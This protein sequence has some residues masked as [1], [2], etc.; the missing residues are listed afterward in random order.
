LISTG[1]R[2][3]EQAIKQSALQ[4]KGIGSPLG[5][6]SSKGIPTVV[7]SMIPLSSP[8][9]SIP[10][11]SC[12]ALQSSVMPRGSVMDYQQ[13][14]TT[15]HPYQTPPV[16][17]FVGHNT[18]W[19]SQFPFRGPWMAS[20]QASAPDASTRL[21]VLPNTE[22]IKST[23]L[24]ESSVLHSSGI[25]H[26]S[27]GPVVH[28][29]VPTST[30]LLDPKEVIA[31]PGQ[32]TKDPKSRRR[33]KTP[34]SEDLGQIV[35]QPQFQPEP[36]FT[37]AL[38]SHLS[39]SVAIATPTGSASKAT[40]EKMVLSESPISC[41][42]NLKRVSDDVEQRAT[43]SEET[44]SKVKEARLQAENAAALSAA[45]VSN[46]QEIWSQL[47]KQNSSGLVSDVEAKLASAAVAIAAAAAVAKAAAAA[48]N[49]ASSAALQAKLM[50]EEALFA[51]GYGNPSQGNGTS[52]PDSV[53]ILGKAT[54]ASILK[55]EN[56]TNSSNSIIIA[57]KEAVRKRVE[58]ASAAT[59]RAENM[60]AIVK[61]AELAAEAISQA[62]K[63]VAMGDPLPLS[64]LVKAGPGGFW[65]VSREPFEL[66][67]KPNDT[68][69]EHLNNDSIGGGPNI[70][71]K[72]S[73]DRSSDKKE[74][75]ITTYEK[76]SI[77]TEMPRESMQDQMRLVDGISATVTTNEKD[78]RGQKGRK[79][80]DLAKTIGVV[81][82]SEIGSRFAA[83]QNESEKAVET[84]KQNSIKEGSLVE[85]CDL[86][87]ILHFLLFISVSFEVKLNFLHPIAFIEM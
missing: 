48:A 39:T 82:E 20:P 14:L 2:T 81:P 40:S 3:P 19:I 59:K 64:E 13:V 86:K 30:P 60:D 17:N 23:P 31:S 75:Q 56:G 65:K 71:T 84:F 27:T 51:N 45:A 42:D 47:E 49:V 50:A 4:S 70:S 16:R 5:R 38:T 28:S 57:A 37:P 34:V 78:S 6:T 80:S 69:R 67:V 15:L 54:P 12:D 72:K 66:A 79:V 33:R 11:P 8:L 46:S 87:M 29:V 43:L 32:N 25:K 52:L 10:T 44:L 62:G 55:G 41:T 18:S 53:N 21:S 36:V 26:V 24:K 63:I 76:S 73:K 68:N 1:V 9:W 85:V 77:P 61:A 7:N 74:N 22:T 83:V 58:A 35:L